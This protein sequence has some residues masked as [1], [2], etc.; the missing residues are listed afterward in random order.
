MSTEERRPDIA[1][2]DLYRDMGRE[3]TA[4]L[5]LQTQILFGFV[6]VSSGLIAASLAQPRFSYLDIGVGFIAL[7]TAALS[8]HHEIITST[9]RLHQ[10]TLLENANPELFST[11][12]QLQSKNSTHKQHVN[13]WTQLFLYLVLGIASL[14][15][16]SFPLSNIKWTFFWMSTGCFVLALICIIYGWKKCEKINQQP[17]QASGDYD[18][19]PI[20]A[21]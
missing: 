10:K 16:L 4:R 2:N 9:L 6:T 13:D 20:K 3:I 12:L 15:A 19:T 11:W 17:P 8:A 21:D 5:Q 14:S 7:F 1:G 18:A